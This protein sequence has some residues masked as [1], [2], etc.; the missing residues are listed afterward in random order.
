MLFKVS[1]RQLSLKLS[2]SLGRAR[3]QYAFEE[4][5]MLSTLRLVRKW[6]NVKPKYEKIKG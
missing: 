5:S 6:D 3:P 2:T 4:I 1:S